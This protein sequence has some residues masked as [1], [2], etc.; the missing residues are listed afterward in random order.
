MSPAHSVVVTTVARNRRRS[1]RLLS[2]R[3]GASSRQARWRLVLIAA[4]ALGAGLPR[5]SALV[6]QW[7]LGASL[8]DRADALTADLAQRRAA[9][10]R[11]ERAQ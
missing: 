7:T 2:Q 10:L 4:L 1:D 5:R 3:A 9:L 6:A 8:Q 11:R